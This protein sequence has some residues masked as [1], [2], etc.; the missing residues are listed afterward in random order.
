MIAI[1]N[2][3]REQLKPCEN[4]NNIRTSNANLK[5]LRFQDVNDEREVAIVGE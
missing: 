5:I 3:S 4:S 2:F 1:I